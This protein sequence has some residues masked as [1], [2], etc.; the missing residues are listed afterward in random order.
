MNDTRE[1][2]RHDRR[3]SKMSRKEVKLE[4][5]R[6]KR[7]YKREEKR[8]KKKEKRER[9]DEKHETK[10]ETL[11]RKAERKI[12]RIGKRVSAMSSGFSVRF[13]VA[14]TV[15]VACGVS[16]SFLGFFRISGSGVSRHLER[17]N[18]RTVFLIEINVRPLTGIHPDATRSCL[19]NVDISSFTDVE[20]STYLF[21]RRAITLS[22]L[23]LSTCRMHGSLH[24]IYSCTELPS[25]AIE[26][27][28]NTRL[29]R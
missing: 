29:T 22:D 14:C 4:E 20:D 28:I 10:E 19:T 15:R 27:I 6:E 16:D 23:I 3:D 11:E 24:A 17:L 25:S 7:M 2:H 21:P 9:K 26:N 1:V 5:N 12:K 18:A 13:S 8:D